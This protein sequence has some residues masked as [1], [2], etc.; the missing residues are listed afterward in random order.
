MWERWWWI[1]QPPWELRDRWSRLPHFICKGQNIVGSF[2]QY[3]PWKSSLIDMPCD[4]HLWSFCKPDGG[5]PDRMSSF[6]ALITCEWR[7]WQIKAADKRSVP[8]LLLWVWFKNTDTMSSIDHWYKSSADLPNSLPGSIPSHWITDYDNMMLVQDMSKRCVNSTGSQGWG[9][10]C[11][12]NARGEWSA[13]TRAAPAPWLG[14]ASH[15]IGA[16]GCPSALRPWSCL[17]TLGITPMAVMAGQ[18]YQV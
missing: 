4:L 7:Q 11:V 2:L 6:F 5:G 16:L 15:H 12:W 3:A 1:R 13:P 10:T 8:K 18:F 14:T 17:Q 9:S